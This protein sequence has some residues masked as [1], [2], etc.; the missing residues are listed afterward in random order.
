MYKETN[1]LTNHTF[2]SL[3][4]CIDKGYRFE[5]PVLFNNNNGKLAG[6]WLLNDD[7]EMWIAN[8]DLL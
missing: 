1:K 3:Y 8:H 2:N 7:A 4:D 5:K 6:Y